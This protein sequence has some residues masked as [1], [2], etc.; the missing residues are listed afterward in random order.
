MRDARTT[1]QLAQEAWLGT[2]T[3]TTCRRKNS[4]WGM[5]IRES[6]EE[7]TVKLLKMRSK[8]KDVEALQTALTKSGIKPILEVVGKFGKLTEAAVRKLQKQK[9][10]K[11]MVSRAKFH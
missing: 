7:L 6:L 9:N 8:G 11:L 1:V 4:T 2:K 5:S 10:S 3:A